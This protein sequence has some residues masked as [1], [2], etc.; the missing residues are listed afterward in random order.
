[1]QLSVQDNSFSTGASTCYSKLNSNVWN[2]SPDRKKWRR[3]HSF[4]LTHMIMSFWSPFFLNY[5]IATNR[6]FQNIEPRFFSPTNNWLPKRK[7]TCLSRN[8]YVLVFKLQY[9]HCF[10]W[11][12]NIKWKQ[13]FVQV[14]FVKVRKCHRGISGGMCFL[15]FR[16]YQD[17]HVSVSLLDYRYPSCEEQEI[18]PVSICTRL[19]FDIQT[20]NQVAIVQEEQCQYTFYTFR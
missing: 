11:N 10:Y 15:C 20:L 14:F 5:W 2:Y 18:K 4:S 13:M 1:M 9:L 12:V 3:L 6:T 19:K 17:S 7:C 16:S 8:S